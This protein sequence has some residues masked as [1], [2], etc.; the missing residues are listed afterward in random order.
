M[1]EADVAPTASQV[2]TAD[3]ARA[4]ARAAESR[5]NALRTTGLSSLNA[6][7]KA[8]GQPAIVIPDAKDRE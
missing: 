7:R 1:Q 5:W 3:R 4:Q 8:A 2:A 6:K